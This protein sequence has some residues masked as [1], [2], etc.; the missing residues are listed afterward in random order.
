MDN[1]SNDLIIYY[2]FECSFCYRGCMFLKRFLKLRSTELKSIQSDKEIEKISLKENS[3]IVKEVTS[4][5][6]FLRS[7]AFWR[8][9]KE[10]P[11]RILHPLSKLPG[12]I[13]LGDIIY[14]SVANN[15]PRTCT[16]N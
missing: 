1:L 9:I 16:I 10:S 5:A 8:L 14:T 7:D 13:F 12:V 4:G 15:R 6:I 3:W 2:D 11:F